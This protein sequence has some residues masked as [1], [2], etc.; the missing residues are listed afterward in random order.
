MIY[1]KSAGFI[2]PSLNFQN[3]SIENRWIYLY[4]YLTMISLSSFFI[5]TGGRGGL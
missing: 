4:L 5:C 3:W 1:R 2:D